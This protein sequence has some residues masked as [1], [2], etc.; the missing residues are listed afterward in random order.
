MSHCWQRCLSL[1]SDCFCA[2]YLATY[3]GWTFHFIFFKLKETQGRKDP[4]HLFSPMWSAHSWCSYF[5]FLQI[6]SSTVGLSIDQNLPCLLAPGALSCFVPHNK[7]KWGRYFHLATFL[8]FTICI[9][10][11]YGSKN[12]VNQSKR[13]AIS[14]V[15]KYTCVY[16]VGGLFFNIYYEN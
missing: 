7:L 13:A 11:K 4:S 9:W 2:S 6:R 15:N 12:Q 1:P 16:I 14:A 8:K 3:F 5:V 10:K